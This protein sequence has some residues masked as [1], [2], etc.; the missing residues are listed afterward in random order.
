MAGRKVPTADEQ[1]VMPLWPDAGEC[2]TLGRTATYDAAKRG[3]IPTIAIGKRRVVPTD[4]L[5]ALLGLDAA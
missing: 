4:K 1:P 2:L 5:R 3:D